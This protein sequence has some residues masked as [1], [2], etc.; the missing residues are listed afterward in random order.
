MTSSSVGTITSDGDSSP[1]GSLSS[2]SN[3]SVPNGFDSRWTF[4]RIS[5]AT[6]GVG[7]SGMPI[8]ETGR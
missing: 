1:E 5:R 3:T 7:V 8:F 4:S 6:S 2:G